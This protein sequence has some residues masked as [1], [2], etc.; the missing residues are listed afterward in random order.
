MSKK[1]K[2][3]NKS[4]QPMARSLRL[5]GRI[6]KELTAIQP[7][8]ARK[9]W[10][11]AIPRLEAL[12]HRFPTNVVVLTEL[13]NA[14]YDAN[15]LRGYLQ[16]IRK[17]QPLQPRDG[18][19]LLGLGGAYLSNTYPFAAYHYLQRFVQTFPDHERAAEVR[20][21]LAD[22]RE[23]LIKLTAELG[24]EGE[25]G[26]ALGLLQD[27]LRAEVELG[28]F[29]QARKIGTELLAQYPEFVPAL[30]NLSQIEFYEGEYEK[31]LE[32]AR[33]VLTL[34][35]DN[36]QAAGNLTRFLFQLGQVAEAEAL[37]D[38]LDRLNVDSM[39]YY[40]KKAEA[41]TYLG[42]HKRVLT[43]VAAG[44]AI[45]GDSPYPGAGIL[46]H[47][48]GVAALHLDEEKTA[49]QHWQTALKLDPHLS[50][51]RENLADLA[52]PQWE[53]HAPWPFV[54][55]QWVPQSLFADLERMLHK[56]QQAKRGD[57]LVREMQRYL[58][59]H[60]ALLHLFD[61]LLKRGDAEGREFVLNMARFSEY[62]PLYQLLHEYIMGQNGPDASR[63]SAL[64]LLN[65]AQ[66]LGG[67]T[68]RMWIR[69]EWT[70]IMT[71]GFEIGDEG[72]VDFP[73]HSAQAVELLTEATYLMQA[74][75]FRKAKKLLEQAR[76]LEPDH[77]IILNNLAKVMEAEGDSADAAALME[78]VLAAHPD[79]LFGQVG[80][81]NK[82]ILEEKLDQV[83]AVLNPLL[84]RKKLHYSEF[85]AL[86]DTEMRFQL[87]QGRVDG[88]EQW[89]HMWQQIDPDHPGARQWAQRLAL[90]SGK[91][92]LGA[93]TDRLRRP[94][95]R[96]K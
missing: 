23:S 5:P 51:A 71:M 12:H 41:L 11:Q 85:F 96:R 8:L 4:R 39:E 77:P 31:A 70:E 73:M 65:E 35:P 78:H 93:L 76:T 92:M 63:T 91:G 44:E 14:C 52:R 16:S 37:A 60:P 66:Q 69:G 42:D 9:Q 26:F 59:E 1:K 72:E 30:N 24:V 83:Q 28:D 48:G 6:E 21:S 49:R 75:N 54:L 64:N 3:R 19:L 38:H 40:I 33:R 82:L 15:D 13:V 55:Q 68:T 45:L 94:Q 18:D 25:A 47:F 84:A 29:T 95:T 46:F 61:V 53:R 62:P 20:Q 36:F 58:E 57:V 17:L 43:A 7:L 80:L 56:Q 88:A 50:V 2:N 74:Q 67:G 81:A 10:D 89:L 34:Q 86:A 90:Q 87:A 32:Y 22:M 79:Y 27:R